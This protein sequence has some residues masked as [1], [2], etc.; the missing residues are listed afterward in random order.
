MERLDRHELLDEAR[1]LGATALWIHFTPKTQE[2]DRKRM[3]QS[4]VKA[5]QPP[6]N[7]QRLSKAG[8][9]SAAPPPPRPS[10]PVQALEGP[11]VPVA[12]AAP[13]S[14]GPYRRRERLLQGLAAG[15]DPAALPSPD[16]AEPRRIGSL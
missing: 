15:A 13:A 4:L 14:A 16:H 7:R 12:E 9:V 1:A 10:A 6:L 8:E 3:V 5:Y 2:P 11:K